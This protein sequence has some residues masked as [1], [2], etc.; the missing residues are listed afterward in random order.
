MLWMEGAYFKT[1]APGCAYNFCPPSSVLLLEIQALWSQNHD[2]EILHCNAVSRVDNAM[3]C[4]RT[5]Y[6]RY[7]IMCVLHIKP[8]SLP[9]DKQ[10]VQHTQC[11]CRFFLLERYKLCDHKNTTQEIHRN[12]VS[13]A[14]NNAKASNPDAL[15]ERKTSYY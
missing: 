8:F 13:R 3:T 6:D 7:H 14:D 5:G 11:L 1:R 9:L 10:R 12:A 15:T 4:H 2:T